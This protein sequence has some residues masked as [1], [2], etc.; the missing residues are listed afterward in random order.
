MVVGSIFISL[1]EI[2]LFFYPRNPFGHRISY[3]K[4]FDG[5][6][7]LQSAQSLSGGFPYTGV[8]GGLLY[9]FALDFAPGITLTTGFAMVRVLTA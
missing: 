3:G 5:L 2:F 4:G 8:T 7:I 9:Q 6:N 1:P